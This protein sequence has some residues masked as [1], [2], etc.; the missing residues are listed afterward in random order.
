MAT[1]RGRF[2]ELAAGMCDLNST[3]QYLLGLLSLLPAMMRIPI[4]ELTPFLPLRD[5]ICLALMGARVPER[6]LLEW[7]ISHEQGD[8][9]SCDKIAEAYHLDQIELLNCYSDAVVWAESAFHL[10]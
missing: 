7:L 3:E 9:T 1:I 4:G 6:R 5:E 2:C 10:T 8:W